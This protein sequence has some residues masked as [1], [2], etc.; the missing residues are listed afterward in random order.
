MR[1]LRGVVSKKV[2]LVSPHQ[3]GL[4]DKATS[5]LLQAQRHANASLQLPDFGRCSS[6]D[7]FSG[8]CNRQLWIGIDK[9]FYQR[10]VGQL[11]QAILGGEQ[12]LAQPFGMPGNFSAQLPDLFVEVIHHAACYGI[13]S[14]QGSDFVS[15]Q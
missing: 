5:F 12:V 1:I 15:V 7:H 8:G 2:T 10:V 13:R 3:A 11:A 9:L 4:P 6:A 14:G